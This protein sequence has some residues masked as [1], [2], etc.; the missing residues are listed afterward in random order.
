MLDE[1]VCVDESIA[2]AGTGFE[3]IN[4]C[5]ILAQASIP[6]CAQMA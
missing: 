6:Q 3:A 1:D 4:V 2:A 5:G